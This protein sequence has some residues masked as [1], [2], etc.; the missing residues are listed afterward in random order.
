MSGP[1]PW[2]Q[3][4]ADEKGAAVK[5]LYLAGHSYSEITRA[6]DAPDRGSVAGVIRRLRA[7]GDLAPSVRRSTSPSVPAK[8]KRT[9][10]VKK[11][12]KVAPLPAMS[13]AMAFDPLDGI[14]PVSLVSNTG[15]RWPV[16]GLR[17]PGLLACGASRE[18]GH[19]YC[20]HHERIAYRNPRE[21]A[22]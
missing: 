16:D 7:T 4:S 13:R 9:V 19:V 10:A 1:T 8:P 2:N 14:A 3:L 5:P 6:V 21:R 12:A 17:G 15:C 20:A 22:A 18:S 11:P